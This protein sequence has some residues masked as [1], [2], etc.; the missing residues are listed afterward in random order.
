MT[1]SQNAALR[2]LLRR[3]EEVRGLSA[4]AG[5]PVGDGPGGLPAL[6]EI[7]GGLVDDL[8]RSHR[9]LIETNI[10]LVSLREVAS[11]MIS[12]ADLA[13]TTRTV[14]RY[15]HRAFGFEAAYVA[16][17]DAESH[18]LCGTW[19]QGRAGQE[20]SF[21]LH[22]PLLGDRGALVRSLWLNQPLLVRD[23]QR[24]PLTT[25]AADGPMVESLDQLASFAAVPLQRSHSLLPAGQTHELCGARCVLGDATLLV[26]PPGADRATWAH[27]R[28]ERQRHCLAC[29]Q[30]PVLGALGAARLAGSAPLEPADLSLL[31]SIALSV[32]PVVENARLYQ[33]LRRSERFREH[34][35]HSMQA[36]LVAVNLAGEVLTI[37]R[38]ASELTGHPADLAAGHPAAELFGGELASYLE[39][40]LAHGR[41]YLRRPTRLRRR[42][43][44]ELD[45]SLTTSLL[46]DDRRQVYGVI[47]T[48]VDLAPLRRA[49]EQAR[50]RDRLAALGR[51]TSSV[52]HEIRNPLTGIAAGI[53][54]LSRSVAQGHPE[55]ENLGFILSEVQRLDRIVQDLFD[56]THPKGL[57]LEPAPL[58]RALDRAL[59][60]LQP[61]LESRGVRVDVDAGL[62]RRLV[63]HD[64]DQM[65]QVFIN[66][67][68]NAA[69]AS[70]RGCTIRVRLLGGPADPAEAEPAADGAVR[71][72][73]EDEGAGIA[74]EHLA[75]LFE[76]FFTTKEGGTGLGLY[77]SHDVVRRHGGHLRVRSEPGRGTT[78]V[79]ELPLDSQGGTS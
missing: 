52:A 23:P 57:K 10:Q 67:L 38:A 40:T 34:V 32:A 8:E 27:E 54:Y 73:V 62:A 11:R 64:A 20:Q 43:G 45:A 36:A 16:I 72:A 58:Q 6:I 2:E 18:A 48:L 71:V 5:L 76:P 39:A 21:K 19:T 78:F 74:P 79:I 77:V 24:H 61:V 44:S 75:N 68:K 12:T 65:Q 55:R 28:E 29:E 51:F 50:Q 53:Q 56:I 9:R 33:E 70:G 66:L 22:V 17:V 26:P 4:S 63:P 46:R 7:L 35:F 31:E 30:F 41:E 49:E 13:E 37:N 15:L 3:V 69:E 60:S 59:Q 47:A 25:D 1:S 14:T 42:D